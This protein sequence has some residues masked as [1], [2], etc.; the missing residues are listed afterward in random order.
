MAPYA[1]SIG[2][3]P[4]SLT[5]I[6]V[7]LA[8]TH[9][10]HHRD[11]ELTPIQVLGAKTV[12]E[13][14]ECAKA[15]FEMN[16]RKSKRGRPPKNG[17][18]WIIVRTPDGTH[19]SA[20]EMSAY[21]HTAIEAAGCGGPV[22]GILNW[23]RN[24]YS[25]ADDLN[26]LSAAF[27][28]NG[29]L[30]RDRDADPIKNLRWL[31]DQTTDR[32]NAIRREKGIAQILTMSEIKRER[33]K[34]RGEPDVVEQLARLARRPRTV[35]E[36]Q[37]SLLF[38][39]YEITRC[40]L[41]KD[42]ISFKDPKRIKAKKFRISSLLESVIAFFSGGGGGGGGSDRNGVGGPRDTPVADDQA[43]RR[44]LPRASVKNGAPKRHKKK[45]R[46]NPEIEEL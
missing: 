43:P 20:E 10:E 13:V 19:L 2:A 23:H 1:N 28:S 35:E 31:M 32:L 5:S 38:L 3:T 36:I 27:T 30:V 34:D 39:G 7:Y 24:L 18:N 37:P 17:G 29:D 9:H 11:F 42:T 14:I 40:S 26:L 25:G 33:A 44:L 41:K 4:A 45:I 46:K 12:K 8:N 16:R 22:V 6:S 21:E 15:G